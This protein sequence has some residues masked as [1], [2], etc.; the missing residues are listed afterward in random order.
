MPENPLRQQ[1]TGGIRCRLKFF[2]GV[3]IKI[4]SFCWQNIK[5]DR[6]AGKDSKAE[7]EPK[8]TEIQLSSVVFLGHY[9]N[10]LQI[11]AN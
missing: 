7:R 9:F 11:A 2:E 3:N 6:L 10:L 4:L 8:I 5:K 1:E